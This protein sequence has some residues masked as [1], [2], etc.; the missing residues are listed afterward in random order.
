MPGSEFPTA[1]E[2]AIII[3]ISRKSTTGY[4]ENTTTKS[5]EEECP[6]LSGCFS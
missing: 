3:L 1:A 4:A 5:W 6:E 2:A